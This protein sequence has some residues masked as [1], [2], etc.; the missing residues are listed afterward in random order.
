MRENT[1]C[2]EPVRDGEQ[3]EEETLGV[4]YG[5]HAVRV[6][7]APMAHMLG[8]I[9]RL[10]ANGSEIYASPWMSVQDRDGP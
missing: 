5:C 2:A 6:A 8:W 7:Y 3:E 10:F 9:S 4:I 1:F